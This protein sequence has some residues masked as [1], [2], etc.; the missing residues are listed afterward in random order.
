MGISLKAKWRGRKTRYDLV[1]Y[2]KHREV[3][4]RTAWCSEPC[5]CTRGIP[6]DNI[7]RIFTR[8]HTSSNYTKKEGE[9]SSGRHGVGSKVTNAVSRFF[10]VESYI[11]GDARRV[12]FYDGKP[13]EKGE[14]KI[15]NPGKQGTQVT[16]A[17]AYEV[18]GEITTTCG[19]ILHLIKMILPLLKIG[20]VIE[21]TGIDL[22]GNTY[23]E[24]LE[25]K[26]GI[27]TDLI[28]KT[29]SPLIKPIV[30]NKV[31]S[32]MKAEIAFTYD[33]SDLDVEN[34][35]SFS[36]FC[37]TVAG[38]HV[39]GYL[40]G[41]TNFFRDYMNK[42]FISGKSKLTITNADIKTG[43]KCIISVAH[44]K[45]T[46]TGQAKEIL[47][48]EDMKD[49]VKELVVEGLNIW[50]RENPQELQKLC[51]YFKDVAE[52]RVKGEETKVKVS[53]KYTSSVITGLPAK[54]I[55]PTGKKNLELIIMEGDSASSGGSKVRDHARQGLF[56]IKGKLP[57]ALSKSK[58]AFLDNDEIGA[59]ISILYMGHKYDGVGR[60]FN[61]DLVP[62]EKIIIMTDADPDAANIRNLFLIFM[63]T[64]CLPLVTA[65]RVY[66]GQPP[67][68]GIKLRN[69]NYK[70]FATDLDFV[71]YVQKMFSQENKLFTTSGSSLTNKEITGLLYTNRK[72]KEDLDVVANTYAIN[73]FLLEKCI[74]NRNEG[75][76]AFKK[77]I[78]K[79]YRFLKVREEN[80]TTIIEGLVNSK[81][82]T[83]IWNDNLKSACS[84][85]YSYTDN[86]I[87]NLVMND[88][89]VTLYGLMNEFDQFTPSG[90][91]RYKGLG[92]M[93][94]AQL[95]ES[96]LHPDGDRTLIRYTF[97]DIKKEI[98]TIR[99]I[100]SNK[101]LLL[102]DVMPSLAD[103]L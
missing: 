12:E 26:D 10:Y 34:I 99:Y 56:P 91:V 9:F 93:N 51:R 7:I 102:Q 95:K 54:F 24:E 44:L 75:F 57:N 55:K 76:K 98:E 103:Q 3:H 81:Y 100:E 27:I 5:E 79:E 60:A 28:N 53:K 21:F 18:M 69:G 38:T 85:L 70:Y 88:K 66:G 48:N 8:E 101:H 15:P 19:D 13:W 96:A 63:I 11:L 92:E 72:Y 90:K 30:L 61:I 23:H 89:K 29:T 4:K 80:N 78:E 64:Y 52:I 59:I 42:I 84:K 41:L 74:M 94:A 25:N 83:V 62:W 39:D 43:L 16:F 17:P 31:I 77:D 86:S 47:S 1:S 82:H 2:G 20:A 49:F 97:D 22:N 65:G 37:P 87:N 40:L 50:I 36:N 67:L 71:M 73:P 14:V 33:S 6:F 45:P 68:Y 58:A 32:N 35:T 46:F